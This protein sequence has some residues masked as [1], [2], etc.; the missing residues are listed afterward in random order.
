MPGRGCLL[1]YSKPARPGR[2]KTRLIGSLTAEQA[3]ELH[4]AFLDDLLSRLSAGAF[5]LRMAWA[6]APGEEPPLQTRA[7]LR[8][9]GT[10]LGDRLY[11]GLAA[12]ASTYPLVAAVGSDHPELDAATVDDGF[13]RLSRGTDVVLGPADDGGYYLI[14]VRSERLERW[15]FEDIPW[16]TS[17]VLDTTIARCRGLGLS[18]ALLPP[19]FDIDTGPDLERLTEQVASGE[20]TCP[21]TAELLAS[22]GRLSSGREDGC[23]Q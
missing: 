10:D 17:K 1:V 5:D 16:S 15:L 2:V 3:A 12:V 8:Q 22:W 6:L 7:W 4:A 11:R 9:E 13:A 14:G 18:V 20:L 23:E 19:G 21:R